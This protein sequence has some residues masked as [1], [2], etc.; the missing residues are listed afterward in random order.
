MIIMDNLCKIILKDF[1][2]NEMKLYF[3]QILSGLNNCMMIFKIF[4]ERM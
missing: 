2:F 4:W 1:N 3:L